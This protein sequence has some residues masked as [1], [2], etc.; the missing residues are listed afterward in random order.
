MR[1]WLWIVAALLGGIAASVTANVVSADITAS[2]H[3]SAATVGGVAL[4]VVGLIVS[5]APF[6]VSLINPGSRRIKRVEHYRD[7]WA[8]ADEVSDELYE[9]K[10]GKPTGYPRPPRKIIR[11]QRR[12]PRGEN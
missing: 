6:L 1:T 5:I 4:V 7:A 12:D 2:D 11:T 10:S 8:M 9:V 3:N